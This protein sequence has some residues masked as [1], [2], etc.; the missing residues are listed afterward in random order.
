MRFAFAQL[1][2]LVQGS[3]AITRD[4]ASDEAIQSNIRSM[5]MVLEQLTRLFSP[6]GEY[7]AAKRDWLRK[8]DVNGEF[9]LL[10][11]FGIEPHQLLD[12]SEPHPTTQE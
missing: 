9:N 3:N 7:L 1:G 12:I 10:R 2:E 8:A 6:E 5:R 11:N 4:G